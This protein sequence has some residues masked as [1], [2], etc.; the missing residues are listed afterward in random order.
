MSGEDIGD[1]Y[2][3][4][5]SLINQGYYNKN[6]S[7]EKYLKKDLE[8]NLEE[9]G[10][11]YIVDTPQG[12]LE[13][14][15]YV[16]EPE[17]D[18]VITL[19]GVLKD[20][21]DDPI[22]H[23]KVKLKEDGEIVSSGV[24]DDDGIVLLDYSTDDVNN[25]NLKCN[26]RY[27]ESNTESLNGVEHCWEIEF[28]GDVFDHFTAT[29]FGTMETIDGSNSITIDWGDGNI[30]QED[31]TQD[32]VHNYSVSD[33]YVIKIYNVKY[34]YKM[35]Q[36]MVNVNSI[37]IPKM[38][39]NIYQPP[40]GFGSSFVSVEIYDNYKELESSMF[41]DCVNLENV[42]LPNSLEGLGL[43]A[44]KNCVNL[45]EITL[46]ET[47]MRMASD[48][49]Y[50][51]SITSITIP[52][53]IQRIG[54]LQG[55][56]KL[57]EINFPGELLEIYSGCFSGCT[58][59]TEVDLPEPLF[60]IGGGAFSGCTSLE[61]ITL[62][63]TLKYMDSG[64][65]SGCS[66]LTEFDMPDEWGVISGGAFSGAMIENFNFPEHFKGDLPVATFVSNS[67]I[68][69]MEFPSYLDGCMG[70][71][72]LAG[73]TNL[74]KVIFP[75]EVTGTI[76]NTIFAGCNNIKQIVFRSNQP[77]TVSSGTFQYLPTSCVIKVPTGSLNN[78]IGATNYPN[79]SNYV[80]EEY[81]VD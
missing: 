55:C 34:P 10:K 20:I 44:F 12:S 50:G 33:V 31:I 64:I 40:I 27:L 65:F 57:Q 67:K 23:V 18:D 39:H 63:K 81:N 71:N 19:K 45:K 25:H 13:L 58:S 78:Y 80:Y 73:C 49:F 30:T 56:A 14:I 59:L 1:L 68:V 72:I 5:M 60:H 52:N 62:P 15:N 4:F 11:L 6:E 29:R 74:E 9:N 2:D 28:E 3:D 66:S 38:G 26:T 35:F 54:G 61:R 46:P 32:C 7:D 76:G 41:M 53:G 42:K 17:I 51:T 36:H 43:S 21:D 48:C 79:P 22:S 69:E 16:A 47:L 8:I 70:D 24:T 37:K 75:L 77:L